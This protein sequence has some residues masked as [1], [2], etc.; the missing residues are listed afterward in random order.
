MASREALELCAAPELLSTGVGI[1]DSVY[2]SAR[3]L[4]AAFDLQPQQV[5]S[6]GPPRASDIHMIFIS[7]VLLQGQQER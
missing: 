2:S 5:S 3:R 6:T 1:R 4:P 7:N